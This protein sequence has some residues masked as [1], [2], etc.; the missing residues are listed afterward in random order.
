M[1]TLKL[2]NCPYIV[3][4]S[5]S[6]HTLILHPDTATAAMLSHLQNSP[7]HNWDQNNHQ[8]YFYIHHEQ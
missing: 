7:G 5:C 3:A 4:V 8:T 1:E 2:E 6:W